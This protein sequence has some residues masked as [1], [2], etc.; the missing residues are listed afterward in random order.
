MICYTH[1]YITYF[2]PV[3]TYST[4]N[5]VSQ[6]NSKIK[7]IKKK[8]FT[9]HCCSWHRHLERKKSWANRF[10]WRPIYTLFVGT[11]FCCD[12]NRHWVYFGIYI[13]QCIAI[14][15][16]PQLLYYHNSHTHRD[17]PLLHNARTFHAITH[18]ICFSLF[19]LD[20]SYGTSYTFCWI[21]IY[22]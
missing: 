19:L 22:I 7:N 12:Y 15:Y 16:T 14:L 1:T 11:F 20:Q 2:Q 17:I 5:R 21:L 10:L 6:R 18:Q 4:S 8:P 3:C 9:C 13:F